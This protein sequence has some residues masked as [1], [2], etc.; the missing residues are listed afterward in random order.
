MCSCWRAIQRF[1]TSRDKDVSD[2]LKSGCRDGRL[3]PEITLG[4]WLSVVI[5]SYFAADDLG[6]GVLHRDF[7]SSGLF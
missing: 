6:A 2:V 7:M 3:N 5:L 4:R 1:E